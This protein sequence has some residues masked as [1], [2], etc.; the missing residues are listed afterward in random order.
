MKK[1]IIIVL[2]ISSLSGYSQDKDI[3]KWYSNVDVDLVIHNKT[4]YSYS[5]IGVDNQKFTIW[6]EELNTKTAALGISY[7]YNYLVF[8]KLSVGFLNGFKKYSDPDFKIFEI[9]GVVKYFF[10]GSNNVYVYTSLSSEISLNKSQFKSG[11]NARIGIGFP[12]L[13]AKKFNVN[14]NVFTE[15]NFLRLDGAQ[16]LFGYNQEKPGDVIYKSSGIS[17]GIKF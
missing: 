15:Q 5:Y 4:L 12:I 10:V 1:L 16:S 3:K 13:R 14:L 17:A 2:L 7:S 6:D 11:T 8:K 9:G